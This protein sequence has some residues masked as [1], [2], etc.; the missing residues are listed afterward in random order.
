MVFH[1]PEGTTKRHSKES[2]RAGAK[3]R[4]QCYM[5][6]GRERK[7]SDINNKGYK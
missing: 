5:R 6:K 3:I 4:E 7:A 1:Y 2:Y